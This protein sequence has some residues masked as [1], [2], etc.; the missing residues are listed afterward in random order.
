MEKEK[1]R[2]I[3]ARRQGRLVRAKDDH[4]LSSIRPG[5]SYTNYSIIC[6]RDNDAFGYGVTSTGKS[7]S[8]LVLG[9]KIDQC[10]RIAQDSGLWYNGPKQ[11]AMRERVAGRL[12]AESRWMVETGLAPR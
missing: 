1:T 2:M 9:T 8:P 11:K 3:S 5:G 4:L 12:K 7:T 6:L 10:L